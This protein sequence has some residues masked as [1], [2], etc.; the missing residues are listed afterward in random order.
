MVLRFIRSWPTSGSR[1]WTV[2]AILVVILAGIANFWGLSS[3][4]AFPKCCSI[5]TVDALPRVSPGEPGRSLDLRDLLA[6]IPYARSVAV[7]SSWMIHPDRRAEF[8]LQTGGGDCATKS[9]ALARI[10]QRSG[11][12]YSLVFIMDAREAETGAGHT[13]VECSVD[14]DGSRSVG[15]VDMLNASI[16]TLDGRPLAV[17]D[18]LQHRPL[19]VELERL[20]PECRADDRYYGDYLAS[21]VVGVSRSEELNRYFDFVAWAY[22]PMGSEGVEKVIFVATALVLGVYP[23]VY[24]TGSEVG[25]LDG[26]LQFEIFLA[27]AVIWAIRALALLLVLDLVA[28][29]SRKWEKRSRPAAGAGR[30]R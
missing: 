29:A 25:R 19:A 18:L 28:H 15:I 5:V 11:I 6:R 24:M 30:E 17:E 21:C 27:H 13:V 20:N 4:N 7:P 9:R 12:P 2:R 1:H 26:W 8:V 22:F 23:A 10:L 3:P 16:V 14:L